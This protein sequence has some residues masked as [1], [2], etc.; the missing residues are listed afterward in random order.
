MLLIVGVLWL[1]FKGLDFLVLSWLLPRYKIAQRVYKIIT[2][3]FSALVALLAISLGVLSVQ[4][5][6][7]DWVFAKFAV[8]V[9]LADTPLD[10]I[11]CDLIGG[12]SGRVLE[13]GP[14]PGTNFKCWQNNPNITEWVGVEPN[15]YFQQQ[16]VVQHAK[17]NMTFP[18]RTIN[19]KGEDLQV[20]AGSFDAVIATHVLCSV[21]DTYGVLRQVKRALKPFGSYYFLEHVA[22]PVSFTDPMYLTQRLVEPFVNILGNG[23]LMKPTWLDLTPFTGLGGFEVDL[24]HFRAPMP[25]PMSPHIKGIAVKQSE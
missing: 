10:T 4:P 21:S 25:Y 18:M 2:N 17:K 11:R 14:G 19:L 16:L 5:D 13:L 22:V 8:V 3:I 12:I 9:L 24:K 7:K 15:K 1:L 23:C 20:D 6:L